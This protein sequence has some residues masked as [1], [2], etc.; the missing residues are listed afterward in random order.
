MVCTFN[1]CTEITNAASHRQVMM[2][3]Y[4]LPLPAYNYI[5]RTLFL[6]QGETKAPP[7]MVVCDTFT[8]WDTL[9][10]LLLTWKL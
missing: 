4:S 7:R 6:S 2:R 10:E 3:Q 5:I 8:K 9:K 1:V